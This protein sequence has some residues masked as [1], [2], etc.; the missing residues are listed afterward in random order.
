MTLHD[1]GL[2]PAS[3]FSTPPVTPRAK[4]QGGLAQSHGSRH[5]IQ[6]VRACAPVAL[7]RRI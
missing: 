7:S 3:S 6:I 2:E 4:G 5:A 1:A